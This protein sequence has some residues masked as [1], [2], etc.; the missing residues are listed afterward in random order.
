MST[1]FLIDII[2]KPF[3]KQAQWSKNYQ[4]RTSLFH[5]IGNQKFKKDVSSNLSDLS[6]NVGF[7]YEKNVTFWFSAE[8]NKNVFFASHLY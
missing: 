4:N 2:L 3:Q 5:F 8:K 1:V 6:L 7:Y